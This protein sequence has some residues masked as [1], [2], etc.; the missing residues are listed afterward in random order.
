[1]ASAVPRPALN[2]PAG[3]RS[4]FWQLAVMDAALLKKVPGLHVLC[5]HAVAPVEK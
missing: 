2:L 4:H 3:H 5:V 1:V